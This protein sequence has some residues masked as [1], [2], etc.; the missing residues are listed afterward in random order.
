MYL[1]NRYNILA[2]MRLRLFYSSKIKPYKC[3]LSKTISLL[4]SLQEMG[5]SCEKNDTSMMS[6]QSIG[7]VY[8]EAILPS[9]Y[10]KYRVRQIF[11]SRRHSGWLFGK[12]VPALLVC[13]KDSRIPSDVYPHENDREVTIEEFLTSLTSKTSQSSE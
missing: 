7:D 4:D 13:E 1:Y 10:K 6:D 2:T 8:I 5:V 11:G 3:D 9:V 12:Q